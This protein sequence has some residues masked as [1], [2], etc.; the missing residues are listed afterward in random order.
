MDIEHSLVPKG[1]S[2]GYDFQQ[3]KNIITIVESIPPDTP[4]SNVQVNYN[5]IE[6]SIY[7]GVKG[8]NPIVCGILYEK[9]QDIHSCEIIAPII[10]I[11]LIKKNNNLWPLLIREKSSKGIDSKSQFLLG[12]AAESQGYFNEAF[13]FYTQ[14]AQKN[15][16]PAMRYLAYIYAS[17]QNPYHIRTNIKE[18]INIYQNMFKISQ[19]KEIGLILA[20]SL[21]K[22][23]RIDEAKNVLEICAQSSNDAKYMLACMYSPLLGGELNDPKRAVKLFKELSNASMVD[24]TK[25]LIQHYEQGVGTPVNLEEAERLRKEIAKVKQVEQPSNFKYWIAFG[26]GVALAAGSF[27]LGVKRRHGS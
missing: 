17:E 12:C 18:S 1:I 3:D 4:Q 7:I 26:A 11:K 22:E 27:Y 15:Y 14:S 24:A 6:N 9:I 8:E 5:V 21:R 10:K 23:R 13:K 25:K 19:D 2:H 16:L 20:K